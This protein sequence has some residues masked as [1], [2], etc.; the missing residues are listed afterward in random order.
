MVVSG[1]LG[2]PPG[3]DGLSYFCKFSIAMAKIPA[4]SAVFRAFHASFS[5]AKNC[6]T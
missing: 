6:Q 1:G 5:C 4:V 2:F 3:W